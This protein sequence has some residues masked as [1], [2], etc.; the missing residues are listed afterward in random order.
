MPDEKTYKIIS[1]VMAVL[2]IVMALVANFEMDQVSSLQQ[3]NSKLNAANANLTVEVKLIDTQLQDLQAMLNTKNSSLTEKNTLITEL[4]T[5]LSNVNNSFLQLI[6]NVPLNASGSLQQPNN[7][8]INTNETLNGTM[9]YGLYELI[10]T[11]PAGVSYTTSLGFSGV[12]NNSWQIIF[13]NTNEIGKYKAILYGY[14]GNGQW[15]MLYGTQFYVV[16]YNGLWW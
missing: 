14:S 11:N 13:H 9:G 1:I 10:I 4:Q 16:N 5:E 15:N 6:V 8:Y 3:Q 2:F 12:L 7:V